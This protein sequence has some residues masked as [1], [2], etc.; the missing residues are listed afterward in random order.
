MTLRWGT[1]FVCVLGLAA[2]TANRSAMAEGEP[3]SSLIGDD[4]P[5]AESEPLHGGGNHPFHGSGP[6][7]VDNVRN[8]PDNSGNKCSDI[9]SN[10]AIQGGPNAPK[11]GT[12][13]GTLE[14]S[15]CQAT[16]KTTMCCHVTAN[17]E[18]IATSAGTVNLESAGPLCSKASNTVIKYTIK[19][20]P[21]MYSGAT[22]ATGTQSMT[23]QGAPG[24]TSFTGKMSFMG[25]K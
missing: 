16:G 3:L 12:L 14:V 9:S 13:T 17:N 8:C 6:L 20:I 21:V 15:N 4:Q 23:F 25:K 7:T 18:Q 19:N 1:I 5:A 22:S 10:V 2:L 24:A 11:S